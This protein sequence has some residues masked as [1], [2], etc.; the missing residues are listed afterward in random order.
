MGFFDMPAGY[1][2]ADMEMAALEDLGNRAAKRYRGLTP[3]QRAALDAGETFAATC[4]FGPKD[5]RE[6][7]PVLVRA[8][9][10][11]EV[12][13]IMAYSTDD[14]KTWHARAKDARLAGSPA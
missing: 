14:G 11:D 10:R 3:E 13:P 9:D 6:S 4:Y 5:A 8:S 12:G 2:D 7:Y 1:N